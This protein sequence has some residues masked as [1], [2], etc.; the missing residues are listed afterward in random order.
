MTKNNSQIE[1][2]LNAI[3]VDFYEK[4]KNMSSEERIAFIKVQTAPVHEK[5]GIH[6]ITEVP[7]N[8]LKKA[9]V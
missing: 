5:Y 2:E 4:T 7:I 3:R 8:Q 1:S 6:V 9:S